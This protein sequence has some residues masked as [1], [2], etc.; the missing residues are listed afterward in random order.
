M[1]SGSHAWED[2]ALPLGQW[3]GRRGVHLLTGGGAGVM[4]SV[5]RAFYRVA[6]RP[7]LVIGILRAGETAGT[8]A[9]GYPNAWVE[10]PI[11]THLPLSGDRGR[12]PGSRNH[13]NVLTA[14][15]VV[16][17]P[18]GAGTASEVGLAHGYGRPVVAWAHSDD[19]LGGVPPGVP[20]AATLQEVTDFIDGVLAERGKGDQRPDEPSGES[21]AHSSRRAGYEDA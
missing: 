1:G 2:R 19:E 18:G 20:R 11:V 10:L 5:S 12:E 14:D 17:L 15:V 16:A 3:L 13:I 8:V 7:G 4:A 21:P 6:D 9:P